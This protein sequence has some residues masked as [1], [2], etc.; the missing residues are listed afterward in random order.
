MT[1]IG[2]ILGKRITFFDASLEPFLKHL[3]TNN[4][5]KDMEKNLASKEKEIFD[6]KQ[7]LERKGKI[8]AQITNLANGK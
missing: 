8:L 4:E 1:P 7:E 3:P 2:A 5:K 6:L